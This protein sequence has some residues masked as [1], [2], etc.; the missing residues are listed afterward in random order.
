MRIHLKPL[1]DQ[2]IVITGAS[3]GIGLVTA[4]SAAKQGAKVLMVARSEDVLRS[5]VAEMQAEGL[6]VEAKAADVG[7]AAGVQAAADYAVATWGRIDTWV[8]DAGS[9]IF[10]KVL[11]TPVNEQ[12]RLFRT[13]YFGSVNGCVAAVPYLKKQGGALITVG[14]LASDMPAPPMG[15]YSATKH[16][17]KAYVEVLRMELQA[18]AVPVSVTLVKPSGI[19]TPIGQHAENHG[20]DGEA[21]IPPPIYDPQLVADAI[22]DCAVH[23]RREVT[24]GGG[25]RA[26]VLF[27]QHFPGLFEWLAPRVAKAAYAP[28]KQQPKPSNLKWGVNAGKERSGEHP[29]ALKTSIYTA[30]VLHP[31]TTAVGLGGLA[32]AVG[33]LLARRRDDGQG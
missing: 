32:L 31:R 33:L 30:A 16:A 11:D 7:D 12:E 20:S 18:D 4:R 19:D 17:T 13:N 24:V 8:N 28:T 15:V 27:S 5:L 9:A 25:G 23:P 14:S 6:T 1:R 2:V 26:Q 29:H 3:S 21:Q 22:L 10:G